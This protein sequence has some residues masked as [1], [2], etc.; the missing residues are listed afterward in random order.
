MIDATLA[1]LLG[2]P[3]VPTLR[4]VEC[5]IDKP[6]PNDAP[7]GVRVIDMTGRRGAFALYPRPAL[8]NPDTV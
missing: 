2:P 5:P 3:S 1:R 7:P 8:P 4:V 6:V